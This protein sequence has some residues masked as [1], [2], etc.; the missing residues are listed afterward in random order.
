MNFF[1]ES[2]A[3]IKR[4]GLYRKNQTYVSLSPVQ[5]E[6]NHRRC[7]VLAHNNYLG[8][9]NCPAVQLAAIEAIKTYGTGSGGSRLT[10]G[11][12]PLYELLE[13]EIASFKKCEAA[14]IFNTGYMANLGTISAIMGKQDIIFSDEL[15]HA[16]IIDGC[17]LSR[18]QCVVFKHSDMKHLQQ[19][20][21]DHPC[22]GKRLIV[23][24][25]VFSMDGDIAP[26]EDLVDIS[27]KYNAMLMVDDAHAT[28]VLGNGRGTAAHF[29]LE[30]YVDIQ[31]GTLSKALGAEGAY[32]AGKK[33]MIEYL[34]N[35]ARSYI[36]STALSPASIAAAR[37]ALKE[38]TENGELIEK[39][40]Q[41]TVF[42]QEKLKQNNVPIMPSDTAI[43]PVIIGGAAETMRI[44]DALKDE[45]ILVSGV[46]PPTVPEGQSRL[47]IA[48]SA[49][50]TKQELEFCARKIGE[51]INQYGI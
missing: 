42:M 29:G 49:A 22:S 33:E 43:I 18:A 28:G 30:Q 48:V 10:T 38:I 35:K 6:I 7:I 51:I 24:D 50:H 4:Q 45:G 40:K 36:F 8:L 5:A 3:E 19:C 2:L 23:V 41:N 26:L 20:I 37:A 13:R 21:L 46:R 34:I 31:M 17:L 27:L 9:A 25:G 32:V 11:S 15:N 1:Q 14:V 12:H 16:S 47:R 44:A 39:L